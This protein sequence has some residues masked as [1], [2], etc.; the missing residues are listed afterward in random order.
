VTTV[1][2][3]TVKYTHQESGKDIVFGIAGRYIPYEE[4]RLPYNGR[5]FLYA[6]GEVK[7]E[8][9]CCDLGDWTYI[10]VPGYIVDWQNTTDDMG[11]PVSEVEP[12]TDRKARQEITEMIQAREGAMPVEFW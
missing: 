10:V 5:E 1:S 6:V 3:R 11:L 4:I 9:S 12:V 7:M 2:V 8:A